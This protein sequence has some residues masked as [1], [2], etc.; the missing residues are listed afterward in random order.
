MPVRKNMLSLM[1]EYDLE[2]KKEGTV[3][4]AY[5][6]FHNDTGRPNFTIYEDTDSWYCFACKEGGDKALF[7]SK[8]EGISYKDAQLKLD[9][10]E[11]DL[12][13]LQEKIDG[14]GFYDDPLPLNIELNIISSKIVRRFLAVHPERSAEALTF[15]K[16][17][18]KKLEDTVSYETMQKLLNE[19]NTRFSK[20]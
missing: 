14:A 4:R 15:L 19:A 6:P 13:E 17:L 7:V 18:D 12:D 9:G 5:C 8:I 20:L 3:L 1:A 2:I 16:D 10:V 11:L